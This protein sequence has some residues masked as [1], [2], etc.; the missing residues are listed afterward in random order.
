MEYLVGPIA[1][2]ITSSFD[3]L[4]VPIGELGGL[5]NPN[6]IFTLLGFVGLGYWLYIQTKYNKTA[7]QT[8][9]IK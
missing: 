1:S 9:G 6:T 3:N 4:L 7:E 8:G 5:L 2:L